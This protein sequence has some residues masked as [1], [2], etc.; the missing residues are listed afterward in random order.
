MKISLT[1]SPARDG[2]DNQMVDIDGDDE[3][4]ARIASVSNDRGSD[5]LIVEFMVSPPSRSHEP[6]PVVRYNVFDLLTSDECR[7]IRETVARF[8]NEKTHD[9][10][11]L[12]GLR[13]IV[14]A[15]DAEEMPF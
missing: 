1:F 3:A 4:I 13:K 8:D 10:R 14:T 12:S 6:A 7:L 5:R 2:S 9:D 15:Y 11:L